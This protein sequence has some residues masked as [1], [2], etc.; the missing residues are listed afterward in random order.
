MPWKFAGS[1]MIIVGLLWGSSV[2]AQDLPSGGEELPDQGR[3]LSKVEEIVVQARRR[4]EALEET[5]ISI[6]AISARPTATPDPLS[7]VTKRVPLPSG[8]R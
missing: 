1:L 4:T 2:G 5:P 6:T 3:S 7:V 8:S